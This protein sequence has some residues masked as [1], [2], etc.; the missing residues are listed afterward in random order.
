[1]AIKVIDSNKLSNNAEKTAFTEINAMNRLR[2]RNIIRMI[3][4]MWVNAY[5]C[6]IL[7]YCDGGDLATLISKKK[8][9]S[10]KKCCQ[11]MQELALALQYLKSNNI[12][13][14]DLKPHNILFKRTPKL[15]L[16][17]AGL[18]ALINNVS[19]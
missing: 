5:I 2:H 8:V 4:Y 7:E 6:I 12:S 19:L 16:K 17:I 10:E 15:T 9:L 18:Y 11:I 14:L 1:M 13:H 3:K